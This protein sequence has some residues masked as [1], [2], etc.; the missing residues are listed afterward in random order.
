MNSLEKIGSLLILGVWMLFLLLQ[1]LGYWEVLQRKCNV[2]IEFLPALTCAVQISVLFFAGILNLLLEAAVCLWLFGLLS[3]GY[4]VKQ[5][6]GL[7]FAK[8]YCNA[9]YLCLFLFLAALILHLHGATFSAGD[10][11]THWGLVAKS[12]LTTDHMP[13]MR[14][15]YIEYPDY[16]L[17]SAVFIYYCMRFSGAITSEWQMMLCQAYLALAF[18]LPMMLPLK[19]HR[20]VGFVVAVLLTEFFLKYNIRPSS[21]QV[22]TLLPLAGMAM[23]LYVF[24]YC[25]AGETGKPSFYLASAF[26]MAVSQIKSAGAFFVAIALGYVMLE[27][28]KDRQWKQRIIVVLVQLIV[29]LLWMKHRDYVFGY[30]GRHGV[31]IKEF[32][33]VLAIHDKSELPVLIRSFVLRL[34]S[35]KG[36]IL[37]LCAAAVVRILYCTAGERKQISDFVKLCGKVLLAYLAYMA[38]L[39]VMYYTSMEVPGYETSLPGFDRYA[40][41]AVIAV[42]YGFGVLLMQRISEYQFRREK[43]AVAALLVLLPGL[44]WWQGIRKPFLLE[45][46][47][48]SA[49]RVKI[50]NAMRYKYIKEGTSCAILGVEEENLGPRYI[51]KYLFNNWDRENFTIN[52]MEDFRAVEDYDPDYLIILDLD[53]P[54]IQQWIQEKYPEYVGKTFID[55]T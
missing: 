49:D 15:A 6:R 40:Q 54:Y 41:T 44:L 7:S 28:K 51:A 10:D 13:T 36:N 34:A 2:E 53:N 46:P 11:F 8:R 39:C 25:A 4:C 37:C 38:A 5:S 20:G 52:S 33:R 29:Y 48:V 35:F 30:A 18:L 31:S 19:K 17:G 43:C 16:P 1:N 26:I 42:L 50:E 3:L 23:L 14:E 27:G 32:S 21:L 12:V 45:T 22:D 24:R 55:L 47:P 9:G